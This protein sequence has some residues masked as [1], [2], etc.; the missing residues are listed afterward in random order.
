MKKDR[1]L[2]LQAYRSIVGIDSA[3]ARALIRKLNYRTDFILLQC[4]AQTYLDECL[5]R[6]DGTMREYLDKRK[7]RMAERY[8]IN[9]YV[10]N[11]DDLQVLYTMGKVRKAGKAFDLAI[12]CFKRIIK[13]GLKGATQG[14]NKLSRDLA[15]ELINDSKFELYRIYHDLNELK[16]ADKYLKMYRTGVK[17]GIKTIFKPLSRFLLDNKGAPSS[18]RTRKHTSRK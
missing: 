14:E 4:I 17:K 8:I 13:L 6:D 5:L 7:W 12:Y 18:I 2:I 3:K 11:P 10:I 16:H 1:T 9:A 15:N